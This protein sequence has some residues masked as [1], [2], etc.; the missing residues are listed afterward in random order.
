[1]NYL[2]F[3]LLLPRPAS[4]LDASGIVKPGD[5]QAGAIV[6]ADM[7]A[8]VI[9]QRISGSCP[10]GQSIRAIAQ[11]GADVTCEVDDTGAGATTAEL[12]SDK[13]LYGTGFSSVT[14]LSFSLAA[15][16]T[17]TFQCNVIFQSTATTVGV[18]LAV[19]GPA[20]PVLA[21][22]QTNIPISL[23]AS[24]SGSARAYDSGTATAS[25]DSTNSNLHGTIWG[26]IANGT[27]ASNLV[28]R[29]GAETAPGLV[30]IK[31][32]SNCVLNAI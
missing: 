30:T 20:G 8:S 13:L 23:T 29:A 32:G 24:T 19:N 1:M 2:L 26:T 12:G 5:F 27:L 22:Y 17:Y 7:D 16:S 4:A 3:L 14:G 31:A 21:M 6:V 10:A 11:N 25:V 15:N 28:L 18:K 9:Q